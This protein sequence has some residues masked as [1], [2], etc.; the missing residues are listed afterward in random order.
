MKTKGT[1]KKWIVIPIIGIG[2]FLVL[3]VTAAYYY[4]GGSNVNRTKEGFDWINNYWCDL[5]SQTAKNGDLNKGRIFGLTGIIILFSSLAFFWYYLPQF[6]HE[7]RLNTIIIR[8]TGL[9]A[10]FILIFVF[11]RF[12]DSIIGI[13][14]TICAIPMAAT[15][16]ELR[17]NNLR[18]LHFLGLFCIFLI[19]LNFFIYV[20]NWWIVILPLL[21]KIALI[22]FLIWIVLIDLKCLVIN[23][24]NNVRYS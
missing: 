12:H 8:Y 15:L 3:F 6:F 7:R 16:S 11:T 19:L 9:T 24:K 4:P 13:G 14:S 18:A 23:P 2:L 22:A 21:Q 1:H 20:T 5:F 10:M 17:K